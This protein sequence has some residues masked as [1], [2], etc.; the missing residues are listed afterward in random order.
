M[1]IFILF[2]Q[3]ISVDETKPKP[4]QLP[5]FIQKREK[6]K[7]LYFSQTAIDKNTIHV[8]A[9][10]KLVNC[11][12]SA[13]F[14]LMELNKHL[15]KFPLSRN[16]GKFYEATWGGQPRARLGPYCEPLANNIDFFHRY[17]IFCSIMIDW[18]P[19][20]RSPVPQ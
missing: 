1:Y 17:L 3:N 2:L 5:K 16:L 10:L 4:V 6:Y 20:S 11:E 13:N 8:I 18:Y 19:K 9:G 12:D 14:R 7:D 15:D